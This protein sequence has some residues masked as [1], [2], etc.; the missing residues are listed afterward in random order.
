VGVAYQSLPSF[1]RPFL[2]KT[3]N[4]NPGQYS[5]LTIFD[6]SKLVHLS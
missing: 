2:S 5:F 6:I 1:G 4:A 3:A